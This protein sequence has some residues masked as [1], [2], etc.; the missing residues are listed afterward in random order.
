MDFDGRSRGKESRVNEKNKVVQ[1]ELVALVI[2]FI[3]FNFPTLNLDDFIESL[4]L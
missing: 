3:I 1:K 4:H 2:P